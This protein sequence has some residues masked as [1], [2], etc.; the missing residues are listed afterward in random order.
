MN[1]A[2]TGLHTHY[3]T[4]KVARDA[5]PEVVRAAYRVLAQK[6]HPD[7]WA[8]DGEAQQLMQAINA[9]YA[10]LMD[11]G[12]RAQH[13]AWI[14]DEERRRRPFAPPG[15]S[16]APPTPPSPPPPRPEPPPHRQEPPPRPAAPPSQEPPRPQGAQ[17]GW[18]APSPPP[19][20][21][22]KAQDALRAGAARRRRAVVAGVL[23][24][25]AALTF[26]LLD[27]APAQ[28]PPG[29][30]AQAWAALRSGGERPGPALADAQS[31]QRRDQDFRRI[32]AVHPDARS[33]VASRGFVAWSLREGQQRQEEVSR[34]VHSGTP[35]EVI[36]L[37][38]QYKE[39]S[40]RR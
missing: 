11:E 4:L 1:A 19:P 27:E 34:I 33:I 2:G 14:R 13:D 26:A 16:A 32:T 18:K 20:A 8:G 3:D 31:R 23:L 15:P 5:P 7:K 22:R 17:A 9:S 36:T 12:Q 21:D 38:S 6:Y 37:L 35:E 40:G 29:P 30:L 28:D 25:G 39:V 24:T 10:V